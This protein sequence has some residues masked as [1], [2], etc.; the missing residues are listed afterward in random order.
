M[1]HI[2][3]AD[4]LTRTLNTPLTGTKFKCMCSEAA[5][6]EPVAPIEKIEVNRDMLSEAEA[7]RDYKHIMESYMGF[8]SYEAVVLLD[9][10]IESVKD[11]IL[12][13]EQSRD[14]ESTEQDFKAQLDFRISKSIFHHISR[15][16]KVA[17]I[18]PTELDARLLLEV[19]RTL[20]VWI[21]T[22]YKHTLFNQN[23]F[24]QG[25]SNTYVIIDPNYEDFY[26]TRELR[27]MWQVILKHL[28]GLLVVRHVSRFNST[29]QA[30]RDETAELI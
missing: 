5:A 15:M 4:C 6:F 17:N 27:E 20:E 21:N 8:D 28:V 16:N 19:D 2:V 12:T 10:L 14:Q 23:G 25:H 30:E 26:E 3:C 24:Y 1:Q 18:K 9:G 13:D 11:Q 7:I 29:V 22:V